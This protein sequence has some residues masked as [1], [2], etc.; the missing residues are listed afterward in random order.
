M[1]EQL[2]II[3]QNFLKWKGDTPQ[4]DDVLVLGVKI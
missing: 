2:K 3:E 1:N 4:I